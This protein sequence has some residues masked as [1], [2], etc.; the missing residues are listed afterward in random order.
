MEFDLNGE[1]GKSNSNMKLLFKK[2]QTMMLVFW[3][4]LVVRI[5]TLLLFTVTALRI[6][7]YVH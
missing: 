2:I 5:M 7:I 4:L 3:N 1:E 6:F